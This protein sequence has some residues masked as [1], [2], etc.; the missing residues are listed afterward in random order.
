[1]KRGNDIIFFL[2][3]LMILGF[4]AMVYHAKA[5]PAERA[6]CATVGDVRLGTDPTTV[7]LKC[8]PRD[9]YLADPARPTDGRGNLVCVRET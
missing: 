7:P 6:K 5:A 8:C 2:L 4:A 3:A 1:M 9:F